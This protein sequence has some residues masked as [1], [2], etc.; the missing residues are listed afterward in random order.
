[1]SQSLLKLTASELAPRLARRE[2]SAEA[3]VRACLERI[4]VRESDVRAWVR[5]GADAALEQARRLDR[6]AVR[7]LLHGLPLGVKDIFD[8]FDFPTEC[9]TRIHAGRQPD[10]DAACVAA[11]RE[12]GAVILGKTVT[13]ELANFNPGKTRNPHRLTHSPGGSSSG[14]AAAVADHMV[15]LALGSQTAGSIV[16]PAGYCGVVG[17][18][19]S[20]GGIVRAGV[21]SLSENLDTLGCL[22]RSVP[23]AALLVAAITGDERLRDL[24]THHVPRFGLCRTHE[25]DKADADTRAAMETAT[26]G[27][28]AAGARVEEVTL[29][30]DFAPLAAVQAR[31]MGF[32]MARNLADERIRHGDLLSPVLAGVLADGMKLKPWDFEADLAVALAARA[33]AADLFGDCDVLLAPS[34]TGEA[35]EGHAHTGDPVFGR[36][37]TLLGLPCVHVPFTSGAT[38]MPVGLQVVGRP[39]ADLQALSAAHWMHTRLAG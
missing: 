12:A 14:S 35:P 8:T 11:A 27:L 19:P 28:A 36:V 30:A 29:P 21:K 34:T 23:D 22:S 38:G 2:V 3:L 39:G 5:I 4:E 26:R 31:I 7:G 25:W 20:L 16:R 9:G 15:P 13:T 37:W 6:G 1:M 33:R 24:D 10:A 18:K 32:E 17:Y